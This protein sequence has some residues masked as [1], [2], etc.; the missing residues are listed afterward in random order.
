MTRL[1]IIE[2]IIL[3]AQIVFYFGCELLQHDHKDVK[4]AI[5]DRIPLIPGFAFVYLLWFP[6]IALFPLFIFSVSGKDYVVYQLSIIVS[7][8][9]STIIYLLFPTRIERQV[10][11]DSRLNRLMRLIYTCDFKGSNC[12]PSLHCTQCYIVEVSACM[13]GMISA[14]GLVFVIVLCSAIVVSTV[15]IKQ[16][17]LIDVVTAIPLAAFSY[18]AG[19]LLANHFGYEAILRAAGLA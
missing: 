16:H 2:I 17:M 11:E 14:G 1:I 15:L 7:I 19:W 13:C 8:I 6:L 12:S 9:T 18:T 4:R 3:G 10:P 5:D